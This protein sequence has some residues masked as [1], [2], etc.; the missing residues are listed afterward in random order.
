M[1]KTVY[2]VT[3]G[4]Y[5][6]YH[7]CKVFLNEEKAL[8]YC[9]KENS[10]NECYDYGPFYIERF[11]A[12]DDNIEMD[13]NKKIY[14]SGSIY[15]NIELDTIEI[16]MDPI[17]SFHPEETN[18]NIKE[19]PFMNGYRY[20]YSIETNTSNEKLRKIAKDAVMKY[21]AEKKVL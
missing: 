9:A 1:N 7:I 14:K 2:I 3:S 18:G 15:L 10:K 20:Y 11:D 21:I 8:S 17:I 6:D 19:L 13:Q 16:D 5:S 12:Y 4:A